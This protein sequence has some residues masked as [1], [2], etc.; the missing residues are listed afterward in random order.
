MLCVELVRGLKPNI[1][2]NLTQFWN[3]APGQLQHWGECTSLYG[4][5]WEAESPGTW[6]QSIS[7]WT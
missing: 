1:G 5:P 2:Q 6:D 4:L 7:E 3:S